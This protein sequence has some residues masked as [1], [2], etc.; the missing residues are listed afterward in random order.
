MCQE[1]LPHVRENLPQVLE[2]LPHVREGSG[3]PL[4][5]F[6]DGSGGRHAGSVG[7]DRTSCKSKRGQNDFLLVQDYLPQVR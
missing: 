3:G 4:S 2:D 6:R 7:V 1:D 5:Q